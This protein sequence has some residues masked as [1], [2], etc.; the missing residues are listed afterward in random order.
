M[1]P[2]EMLRTE[3]AQFAMEPWRC[4]VH[5]LRNDCPNCAG[6]CV[7]RISQSVISRCLKGE[8]WLEK[9][10]L[11]HFPRATLVVFLNDPNVIWRD[12]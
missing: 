8:S 10:K 3:R 2:Y 1:S 6:T 5:E 4:G 12:P 7:R 9:T 11:C